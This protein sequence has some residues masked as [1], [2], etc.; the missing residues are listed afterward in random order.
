MEECNEVYQRV[1]KALRFGL[2]EV[3]ESNPNETNNNRKRIA[4]ELSDLITVANLLHKINP[5]YHN[6]I[7]NEK[8]AKLDKYYNYSIRLVILK[9]SPHS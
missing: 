5:E 9:E 4:Y 3:Q 8:V 1:C 2:E 6:E 7:S